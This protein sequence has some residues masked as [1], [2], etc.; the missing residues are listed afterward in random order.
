MQVELI[1]KKMKS[2]KLEPCLYSN[3]TFQNELLKTAMF[4]SQRFHTKLRLLVSGQ[5]PEC[6]DCPLI[7]LG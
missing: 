5:I 7:G 6:F 3:R 4:G 2:G 1:F